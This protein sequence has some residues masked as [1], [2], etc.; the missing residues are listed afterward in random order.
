MC[1]MPE[2]MQE[3][4]PE[5]M[6]DRLPEHMPDRTPE[7]TP[8]RTPDYMPNRLPENI[9]DRTPHFKPIDILVPKKG[10][11][12]HCFFRNKL[13]GPYVHQEAVCS[14]AVAIGSPA[15]ALMYVSTRAWFLSEHR[16]SS[17]TCGRYSY[18]V[19][20]YIH[21]WYIYIYIYI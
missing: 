13:A 18:H 15:S 9:P 5:Y 6:P 1:Q 19:Y 7:D 16:S 20:V 14:L 12:C 10:L 11:I 2:R 17:R 4:M 21:T 3:R 8:N